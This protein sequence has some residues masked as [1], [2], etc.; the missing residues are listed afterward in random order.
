MVVQKEN[1][2]ADLHKCCNMSLSLSWSFMV[3]YGLIVIE[4]S[5]FLL[6]IRFI[7][8]RSMFPGGA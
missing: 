2:D 1:M 6:Q 4:E 5:S 7:V 8:R 3:F